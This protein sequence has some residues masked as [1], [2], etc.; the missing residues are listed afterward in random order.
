MVKPEFKYVDEYASGVPENEEDLGDEIQSLCTRA[1]MALPAAREIPTGAVIVN[2]CVASG[3][4]PGAK[5][6]AAVKTGQNDEVEVPAD[7]LTD[8]LRENTP[9]G[10]I[11]WENRPLYFLIKA[12]IGFTTEGDLWENYGVDAFYRA[13]E[14]LDEWLGAGHP[15]R[16]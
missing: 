8:Y 1:Y 12:A 13:A 3:F 16:L 15:Q 4:G 7:H 11:L 9:C 10:V 14:Y 6:V 5:T 2:Y